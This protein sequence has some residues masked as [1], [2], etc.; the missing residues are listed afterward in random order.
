MKQPI[1]RSLPDVSLDSA[2][3]EVKYTGE[4][5]LQNPK[6]LRLFCLQIQNNR[7]TLGSLEQYLTNIISEYVYSRTQIEKMSQPG[8]GNP[9]SIGIQA[10]RVMKKNR[11]AKKETGNELGEILL[12]AFLEE[13]LNAPKIFSKVEIDDEN[14]PFGKICDSVHLLKLSDDGNASCYQTVFGTSDIEG[15]I[16]GAIDKAFDT[17]VRIKEENKNGIQLIDNCSLNSSFD[18]N[19]VKQLESIIIPNPKES[20]SND[21]AYGIFLGYS[22]G[23]DGNNRSPIEFRNAVSMKMN[24]DIKNHI[25]YIAEKIKKLDLGMYSFYFYI[26][27]FNDAELDKKTIINH[28]LMCD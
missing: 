5:G 9:N 2:F 14:T 22:L 20:V 15:D 16:A 19:T 23:L 28:L 12:Y 13:K 6:Q 3:K 27:P 7:F 1:S 4:L 8:S 25:K 11:G 18:E 26:V 17:I 21:F 10:L 24:I